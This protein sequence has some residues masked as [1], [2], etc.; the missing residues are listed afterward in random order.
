MTQKTL[1]KN[2]SFSLRFLANFID[3]I[4]ILSTIV[5]QY[6]I[7]NNF[8]PLQKSSYQSIT[9]WYAILFLIVVDLFVYTVIIPFFCNFRTIGLLIM[10]LQLLQQAPKHPIKFIFQLNTTSFGFVCLIVFILSTTIMPWQIPYLQNY[11][12]AKKQ[13]PINVNIISRIISTLS[14]F[15]AVMNLVN[16]SFILARKDKRGIYE[17][18]FAYRVVYLKHYSTSDKNDK[19]KLLPYPTPKIEIIFAKEN[20]VE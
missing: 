5:V 20:N 17:K 7:L 18:I 9:V 16:Y 10:R 6:K 8:L 15:W 13:V 2:S 1:H 11:V 12:E 19:I 3:F 14:A 4:L